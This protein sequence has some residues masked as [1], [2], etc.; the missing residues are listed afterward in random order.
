MPKIVKCNSF[1]EVIDAA[2]R[3]EKLQEGFVCWDYA[4][5]L[6]V[7]VKSK[8]YVALHH[9]KGNNF[10]NVENLI[11]IVLSGEM[12][13]VVAYFPTLKDRLDNVEKKMKEFNKLVQDVYNSIKHITI[14][15]DF[16]KEALKHP[17]YPILFEAKKQNLLSPLLLEQ[18]VKY[19]QF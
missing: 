15:K 14:Q 1:E 12:D 13:E 19:V 3:L 10:E 11:T 8:K 7:K 17:F 5:D 18:Y 4:N 6:R 9:M 2:D 16:A